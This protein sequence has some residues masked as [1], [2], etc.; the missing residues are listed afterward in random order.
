MRIHSCTFLLVVLLVTVQP[1]AAL[2]LS[3]QGL[4]GTEG[5][6][7]PL[8]STQLDPGGDGYFDFSG[9]R[10]NSGV[11]TH[12][13]DGVLHGEVGIYSSTD[14]VIAGTL[15]AS[16]YALT[17]MSAGNVTIS[18]GGIIRSTRLTISSGRDIRIDGELHRIGTSSDG[19]DITLS[20]GSLTS[21]NVPSGNLYIGSS[22]D[23]RT[24]AYDVDG[25][26]LPVGQLLLRS[27]D[28]TTPGQPI[29]GREQSPNPVP[30]PATLVLV[31]TGLM[32]IMRGVRRIKDRAGRH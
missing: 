11:E 24:L 4:A 3:L 14:I 15:D 22:S 32:M 20:L 10:I 1:A 13:V 27:Y 28:I 19:N 17:L 23:I 25:L 18:E 2:T 16:D 8:A 12:F 7:E 30:E 9:V 5:D 29:F 31:G 21:G 6:F 26:N